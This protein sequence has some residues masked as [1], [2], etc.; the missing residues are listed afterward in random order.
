MRALR[1][2]PTLTRMTRTRVI[3]AVLGVS[4]LVLPTAAHGAP[5][6][7]TDPAP[8]SYAVVVKV[9]GP[10]KQRMDDR[11]AVTPR[12]RVVTGTYEVGSV[13]VTG[14]IKVTGT[15]GT[16]RLR[17]RSLEIAPFEKRTV[18]LG[19]GGAKRNAEVLDAVERY[20][21]APASRKQKLA[22]TARVKV[23]LTL[24]DGYQRAAWHAV[25][26]I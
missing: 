23:L 18:T 22:V 16:I 17:G 6:P 5:T 9:L 26:L 7:P 25:R 21:Q 11:V 8:G 12:F 14:T 15:R 4:A 1:H 20:R 19:L 3:G 24:P 2:R 13:R 10:D